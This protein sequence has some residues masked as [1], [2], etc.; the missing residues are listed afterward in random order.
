MKL[1]I[2]ILTFQSSDNYGAL[3]QAFALQEKVRTLLNEYDS[4]EVQI[5]DYISKNKAHMYKTLDISL[6]YPLRRNINSL[7]N[8][9]YKRKKKSISDKFRSNK[10]NLTKP[11]YSITELNKDEVRWAKV[12]VGSDQVWN[13]INTNFDKRYFLDFVIDNQKK[14][15]Y[16]A[17]FGISDI[18]KDYK[19]DMASLLKSI[20]FIS[21]REEQGKEIVRELAK[22]EVIKVLD[23]TLLHSIDFWRSFEV[24]MKLPDKYIL[25]YSLND[26][27]ELTQI[28]IDIQEKKGI[29]VIQIATSWKSKK[30]RNFDQVIPTI[31]QFVF[32]FDHAEIVLTDSFHGVAFSIVFQ[33]EFQVFLHKSNKAH[34]RIESLLELLGLNQ[35]IIRSYPEHNA[36]KEIDYSLAKCE[37]KE[38]QD[39]S[40]SFLKNSLN[41]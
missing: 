36:L 4:S 29:P 38:Q 19:E 34:S 12:V 22:R 41:L 25:L 20:S 35:L 9:S 15:S 14:I 3:L 5:I 6:S 32:L 30:N 10:L 39:I 21:V 16:A 24:E 31:E 33:K 13:P 26:Y 18:P 2:G 8:F 11:Y 23:P 37:L 7:L 27:T 40:I 1:S 28:A 17:S